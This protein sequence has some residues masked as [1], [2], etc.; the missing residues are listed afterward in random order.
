V[1]RMDGSEAFDDK[2]VGAVADAAR[3]GADAGRAILERLPA[4]VLAAKA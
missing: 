1:L 3:I 2:R 4:G